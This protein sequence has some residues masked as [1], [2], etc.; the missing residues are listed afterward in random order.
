MN[1]ST[2]FQF[3]ILAGTVFSI[4]V[5]KPANA[6]TFFFQGLSGS[7]S[8]I[9]DPNTNTNISLVGASISG[10]V[11][12]DS[13]ASISVNEG[14]A[15]YY[16]QSPA[17]EISF[18][19]N[20]NQY[21]TLGSNNG[22]SY[23]YVRNFSDRYL[24]EVRGNNLDNSQTAYSFFD[25]LDTNGDGLASITPTLPM[26][27]FNNFE[28]NTFYYSLRDNSLGNN[29]ITVVVSNATVAVPE[30]LTILGVGTALGFGAAFKRKLAQSL[31]K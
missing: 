1:F 18:T 28:N 12:Y 8:T 20:S 5:C 17:I 3:V 27:N 2:R 24:L 29:L 15:G 19:V 21:Q 14:T 13:N 16:N 6:T 31:K 23:V 30:P 26:L 11:S 22:Y 4:A 10:S 25:F 7:G 9:Y